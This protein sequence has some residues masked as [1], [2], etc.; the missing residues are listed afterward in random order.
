MIKQ[1]VRSVLRNVL[2]RVDRVNAYHDRILDACIEKALAQM[3]D[4]VWK[5]SPL[6]LQRYCKEYGYTTPI[7]VS[8]ETTTGMYYSDLPES[9]LP[10][11]DKAS[12]V[13]RISIPIQGALS[14][15]PMDPREM[16][17]VASGSYFSVVTSKVGYVVR[18]TRVEYYNIPVDIIASG[19]RMDLIIPFSKYDEGDIVLIPEVSDLR[20]NETFVDRCLKI[21][22]IITPPDSKDDNSGVQYRTVNKD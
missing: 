9:I 8:V 12:G 7:P 3:Y 21:L 15:I 13:R 20:T 16:D 11:Q 1:E 18:P 22:R 2:P 10:F 17:L 5:A 19:V 4:D 6:N 14:F